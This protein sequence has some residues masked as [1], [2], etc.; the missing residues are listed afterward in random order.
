MVDL[1]P[2]ELPDFLILQPVF[3]QRLKWFLE[4]RQSDLAS[5]PVKVMTKAGIK[6]V[7]ISKDFDPVEPS[8][9]GQSLWKNIRCVEA[10]GGGGRSVYE[11]PGHR[12]SNRLAAKIDDEIRICFW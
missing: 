11:M 5:K 8:L 10:F 2:N 7:I 3:E 6:Q 9:F 12:Q 4:F 1:F